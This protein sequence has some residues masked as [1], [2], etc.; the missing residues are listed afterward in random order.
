MEEDD[1]IKELRAKHKDADVIIDAYSLQFEWV[2]A[3]VSKIAGYKPNELIGERITE[4]ASIDY[5]DLISTITSVV[6]KK[7]TYTRTLL[8]KSGKKI[9]IKADIISVNIDGSKYII[10]KNIKKV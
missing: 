8:T 1:F 9:K 6:S 7:K 4:F 5:A 3:K 2:S 10:A